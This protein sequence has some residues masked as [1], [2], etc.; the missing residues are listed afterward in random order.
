MKP[1]IIFPMTV[2][3][4]FT[5]SAAF[6]LVGP[7]N[8]DVEKYEKY[9]LI[10]KPLPAMP[11]IPA[12]NTMTPEKIKLGEMLYWDRRVSKTGAT[13]CGGWSR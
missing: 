8:S 2:L 3:F 11:P 13:S 9:K 6:M 1:R 7:A 5:I 12:D 10:F 4:V